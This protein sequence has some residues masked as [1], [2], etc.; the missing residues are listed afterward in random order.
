MRILRVP[1]FML[2]LALLLVGGCAPARSGTSLMPSPSLEGWVVRGGS[3]TYALESIDGT[4]TIV[5]TTAT[6]SPNTFLC[7]TRTYAD[8]DLTLEFRTHDDL[9]SGVQFRSLSLPDYQNGRVHGYQCE[10]DPTPR[11]WTGGIYDEG[12]RGWITDLSTN[13]E[14]RAAFRKG[15]WNSMRIRA[16]GDELSTWINGVAC[17][18]GFRDAMTREGFIGLQVHGVGSRKDPLRS[19][20]RRI[21]IV[22]LAPTT[23]EP[24]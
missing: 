1:V 3:A 20:W 5:G 16:V 22:E 7:T 15:A 24:R 12:R 21:E 10:I 17:V 23:S 9:N 19:M 6:D 4:P 8:F 18:Q 2:V 13:P 14:A 11:A